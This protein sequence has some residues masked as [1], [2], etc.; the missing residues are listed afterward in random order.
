M[1]QGRVQVRDLQ[2]DIRLRPAPMQSDTYAA[3]PRLQGDQNLARLSDALGSFSNSLGNMVPIAAK[4]DKD[5]RI[6]DDAIFQKRM[7]GQTLEETRTE[8]SEG[9]MSVTQDKFSNAAR[10]TVY[11]N[12]WAQSEAAV[13]DDLLQ[14]EFDWDNGDPEEYLAK[15]FQTAIE[16]SGLSDPNAVASASRAW[17][18]YKTS[19]LAKQDKYRI[20]RTNQ[21]TVDAAFTVIHDKAAE[22]ISTGMKPTDFAE[23]LNRMRSELGVKGSL[24]ANEET[25][26]QEYLNAAARIAE[27]NPEYAVA[28]L[29]AEYDGRS[30]KT[31]LSL[32]RGYKD[33]VLQIKDQAAIAIG[34]RNDKNTLLAVDTDADSLLMND[35]LDRAADFT[36][37]DRN[38]EQKTVKADTIKQEAFNRY[39]QRSGDVAKLDKE[40]PVQTRTR[41][42]RKAQFAGLEHPQIK[43]AVT[44]IASAASPDLMQDPEAMA[45]FMEKVQT[46]RWLQD[47]S[48]NTYMAYTSEADRDFMESFRMAK[49]G[50]TGFDGRQFS[51][52]AAME[53]A[54]RTSQPISVD[55]LNFTRE[56]NEAIDRSVGDLATEPGWLW[57]TNQVT[58]WNA[59]AGKQRV[60]GLA[61][62]LVRGGVDQD[63]AIK[64]ATESV[65][66]NS[67]TYK[68][69]LLQLGKSALPDNYA[70]TLDD[71]IGSFAKKNPGV[72]KDREIET[73]DIS[74]MPI[75]DINV[76]GGRFALF[77][78]E[79][80]TYV[81][82]DKSGQPFFISLQSVRDRSRQMAD[83][84]FQKRADG[85]SVN[86]AAA[87][88][89]L[90]A[91][92]DEEGKTFYLDP[93][94]RETFDISVPEPGAKPVVTNRGQRIKK[95][96]TLYPRGTKLPQR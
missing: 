4:V 83:E 51:D 53:F 96:G 95:R 76:S 19:V 87:A 20:D 62:R 33:R 56:Q 22:W 26:D 71:M 9:R 29:D 93:N 41:E 39:L 6:R 47:T 84:K 68:G 38:G 37:T 74:I 5:A 70:E 73:G 67:I 15:H 50:L 8:I 88:R 81:M 52:A 10:Q 89:G 2:S 34:K 94:T 30:G 77:D 91:Q 92:E 82:D 16:K 61:K 31:S 35:R 48:K 79:T 65:K 69:V 80:G 72:L 14:T 42:L 36:Y 27:T 64:L 43:A 85:V 63:K 78:K 75:G 58:P 66:R 3:P 32:Q 18:Q 23:N 7:A 1:A 54:V 44:G 49:D 57:G 11:G 46:A 90:E 40:S 13:M 28:M 55:G 12:K 59:A 17:D 25:L 45:T 24:G 60:A 86:G 21:S